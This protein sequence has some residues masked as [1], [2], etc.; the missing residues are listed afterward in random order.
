MLLAGVAWIA[1]TRL[2]FCGVGLLLLPWLCGLGSRL[3]R[4]ALLCLVCHF[5]CLSTVLGAIS[6]RH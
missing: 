1:L 6:L 5:D 4:V 3:I 2:L